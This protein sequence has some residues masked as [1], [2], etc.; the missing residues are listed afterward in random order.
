MK[1]GTNVFAEKAMGILSVIASMILSM[2]A[3]AAESGA[4]AE[5][6]KLQ[7]CMRCQGSGKCAVCAGTGN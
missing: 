3:I 2:N 4:A 6:G 1:R 7:I 5:E